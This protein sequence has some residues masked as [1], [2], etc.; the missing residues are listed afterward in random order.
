MAKA[1]KSLGP[2]DWYLISIDR[3]QKIGLIILLVLV[4]GGIYLYFDSQRK[5][6]RERAE[7]A[8]A[9]AEE[10]LS[11]LAG[12]QEF[13]TYKAEFDR[14]R[15]RLEQA[16]GLLRQENFPGAESAAIEAQTIAQSAL[17]RTGE[18]DS[19]AQFLSVDGD[20]Q[21]QKASSSEWKKADARTPLYNGDWVK[22][23]DIASAELIFSN[24]SLYTIGP[25]AL[26]EIYSVVNPATSKKQNSV[27]MQVG[28]VE[29]NTTDDASTVKTPGTQVVVSS[30][31]TAQV[32]VDQR[33]K[34]T[35]VM[36]L[37]GTAAV[38]PAAG[39]QA[40]S[41]TS[42]EIVSASADG[43]LSAKKQ[44]LQPPALVAP[45]DNQVFRGSTDSKVQLSWAPNPAAVA[46]QLQVSR[47]RLFAGVEINAQRTTNSATAK[48]SS[49]GAF[50]W[51]VASIDAAGQIGPFST[52]RRF[53]VTGVGGPPT[54]QSQADKTPPTL[55]L[56]RPFNIGGAYYLIEGRVEP[57]ATVY[58]N[59]DET[60]VQSDG[61]FKKLVSF[62]QVG[63]N[64]IIVKAVDPAGNETVQAEK[65]HV[66]E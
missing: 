59:D 65:V 35:Q 30:E 27:Q 36:S 7:A 17:A 44:Y 47:S 4:A 1:R 12:S 48:V 28:S 53:R 63:W 57:G 54:Q 21:F 62:T 60:D 41:L 10:A 49:E 64:T 19:D 9:D 31:S 52:F 24:G 43:S 50:Y 18:R 25:N 2:A 39:G 13:T 66:K 55:Q 51:R 8:V 46:Y 45:P 32:G 29:I 37:K 16:R 38:S 56:K 6:P 33:A 14:G 34:T 61:L 40:V 11:D 5:D 23:G 15:A 58:I 20:V 26:L 42:G 3:L 22:T